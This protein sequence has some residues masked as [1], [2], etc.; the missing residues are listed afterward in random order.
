MTI[1]PSSPLWSR[2]RAALANR[3]G[4]GAI[5]SWSQHR[6]VA[7]RRPVR[8]RKLTEAALDAEEAAIALEGLA[9]ALPTLQV[10]GAESLPAELLSAAALA[11]HVARRC[12]EAASGEQCRHGQETNSPDTKKKAQQTGLGPGLSA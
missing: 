12:A 5:R 1:R 8:T 11:G 2:Q 10:P 6:E 3:C 4:G 9:A 7:M